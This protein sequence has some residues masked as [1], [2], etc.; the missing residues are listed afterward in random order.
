MIILFLKRIFVFLSVASF[1]FVNSPTYAAF[2]AEGSGLKDY[3][4]EGSLHPLEKDL[5]M[6]A[7]PLVSVNETDLLEMALIKKLIDGKG[8]LSSYFGMRFHPIYRS[9]K[10]HTGIDI[11]AKVGTLIK[12]PLRGV[13]LF[14]GWLGGYGK[15]VIVKHSL[16][17]SSYY[18]HMSDINVRVGDYVYE[19]EV[20]GKVGR[21]GVA[22]GPHVHF[23][24]R[25]LGKPIDPLI[26]FS[27]LL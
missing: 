21:T 11:A 10:F 23:E 15:T 26:Y 27:S 6:R 16:G 7:F 2:K 18:A 19:G 9:M 24:I 5:M 13:V 3:L 8:H 25:Y 12:N 4:A 20:L 17:W 22:D 1:V 14:A